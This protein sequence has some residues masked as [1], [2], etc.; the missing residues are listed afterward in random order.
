MV[1][2]TEPAN[3]VPDYTRPGKHL[4]AG[5]AVRLANGQVELLGIMQVVGPAHVDM[6]VHQKCFGSQA[7]GRGGA[8]ERAAER[9]RGTATDMRA[10]G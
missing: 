1:A 3:V 2:T 10:S 9:I 5:I 6:G 8:M 7:T 4:T